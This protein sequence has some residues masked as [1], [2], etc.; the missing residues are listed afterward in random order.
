METNVLAA[1]LL[2]ALFGA[3]VGFVIARKFP[4]LLGGSI[5]GTSGGGGKSGS[6]KH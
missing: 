2:G 4:K 3:G 5:S 1:I 6:Q